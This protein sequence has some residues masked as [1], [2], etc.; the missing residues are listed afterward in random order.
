MTQALSQRTSVT[1]DVANLQHYAAKGL[2]L[3]HVPEGRLFCYNITQ[4]QFGLRRDGLSPRYTMI[5]LLGLHKYEGSQNCNSGFDVTSMTEELL[6]ERSWATNIGDIGLFLWLCALVRPDLLYRAFQD[7]EVSKALDAYSDAR[8]RMTMELSWFLTGL[9]LASVADPKY[10]PEIKGIAE[11]TYRLINANQAHSG[12]FGHQGRGSSLTGR[13]RSRIGSFADQVYP[14]YAFSRYGS[15]FNAGG[16]VK[17]AL[18]C[19]R[20]LC[21][22]QGPLGQWYWH[23]DSYAGHVAGTYPVYSVHQDG[24]APMALFTLGDA[25]GVDFSEAA[26]AGLTWITGQNELGRDLR[27]SGVIWRSFYQ[28]KCVLYT[29]EA[30][31]LAGLAVSDDIDH[32]RVL[33]ECRPYHLGW[34]LYAFAGRV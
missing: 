18:M 4:T 19:A 32:L 26:Y 11:T 14:I 9:S 2:R 16:P 25:S 27:E 7:L 28:P 15:A 23:Y 31:R 21:D 3:M 30:A 33:Y 8:K 17:N 22:L 20:T 6:R 24:M 13:I 1:V 10:F 34:L 29:K 12:L 5:T